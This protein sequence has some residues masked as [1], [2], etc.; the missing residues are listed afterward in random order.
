M[1]AGPP[2]SRGLKKLEVLCRRQ[3]RPVARLRASLKA[4]GNSQRSA[5]PAAAQLL[6]SS[7]VSLCK[8]LLQELGAKRE[9]A[10]AKDNEESLCEE[11]MQGSLETLKPS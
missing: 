5:A 1:T 10:R 9:E 8:A 4:R 11:N 3:C 6:P 7:F 2:R